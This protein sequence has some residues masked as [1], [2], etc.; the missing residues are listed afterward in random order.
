M[1]IYHMN[2]GYEH[3]TSQIAKNAYK[4]KNKIN[5]LAE[6]F[7]LCGC[8]CHGNQLN[9][10]WFRLVESIKKARLCKHSQNTYCGAFSFTIS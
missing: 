7:K 4:S 8:G 2:L 6:L 1:A 10:T 5:I 3:K 9:T